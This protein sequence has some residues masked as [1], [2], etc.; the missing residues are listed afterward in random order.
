MPKGELYIRTEKTK[1]LATSAFVPS[2]R[3]VSECKYYAGVVRDLE[4]PYYGYIDAWMRYGLSLSDGS[5]DKLMTPAPHKQMSSVKN[6][7]MDGVGYNGLTV[8]RVDERVLSL[9]VNI[10]AEDLREYMYRYDL[11]CD[12]VLSNDCGVIELRTRWRPGRYYRLLY[13]SSEQ[14]RQWMS[15]GSAMFTVGF[16]EPHPE[17]EL[18]T[19]FVVAVA[20]T[21]EGLSADATLYRTGDMAIVKNPGGGLTNNWLWGFDGYEWQDYLG[22]M[23][24]NGEAYYDVTRKELWRYREGEW[25]KM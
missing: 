9:D 4:N 19:G 14:F 25:T 22:E 23:V 8:G 5:V 7:L 2:S 6:S 12:E 20:N 10:V 15:G 16:V 13:Q 11:L 24:R 1:G 17:L 18:V 21:E 3:F